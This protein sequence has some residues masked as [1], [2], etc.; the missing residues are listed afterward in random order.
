QGYLNPLKNLKIRIGKQ[1]ISYPVAFSAVFFGMIHLP[2]I[3]FGADL[4]TVSVI[5]L[6]TTTLGFFAASLR[7]NYDSVLPSIG[8]HVTTNIGGTMFGPIV[9]AIL[10][11]SI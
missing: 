9:Y 8:I 1:D 4:I 11:G 10:L 6:M 2:L 5:F 3:F 7:E